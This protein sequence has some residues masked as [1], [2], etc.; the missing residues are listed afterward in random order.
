MLKLK[1]QF[2]GHLM[3]R[4]DSLEK[5]PDAGKHW[6]QEEKGMTEDEMTWWTWV[7]VGFRN[8]WWTGKPDM[9][10]SMGSQ[11]VG[12]N[13]ATELKIFLSVYG[14]VQGKQDVGPS[15]K[16]GATSK[17][18]LFES[19]LNLHEVLEELF[20]TAGSRKLLDSKH[21]KVCETIKLEYYTYVKKTR[22]YV[23]SEPNHTEN[24][25]SSLTSL[26]SQFTW[27]SNFCVV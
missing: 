22:Q 9:M 11:R 20:K 17:G 10:Q 2:S 24:T 21:W 5:D 25:I 26:Y 3:R 6:R 19:L 1:L 27:K 15:R 18:S 8:W 13:W 23:P 16:V 12:H 4:T 7:W 14:Y